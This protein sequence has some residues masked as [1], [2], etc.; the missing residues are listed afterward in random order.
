MGIYIITLAVVL[1]IGNP[2]SA[3]KAKL[4]IDRDTLRRF[5]HVVGLGSGTLLVAIL[6]GTE[7]RHAFMRALIFGEL[8]LQVRLHNQYV[9]GVP[10][11][12]LGFLAFSAYLLGV[13]SGRCARE[14][15]L[16]G[17]AYGL[18][19]VV[20]AAARG[21]KAP[22]IITVLVWSM[23]RWLAGR[24]VQWRRLALYALYAS[25]GGTGLLFTGIAL[26]D[27]GAAEDFFWYLLSRAGVGQMAGLFEAIALFGSGEMVHVEYL[28]HAIPGASV[29][30]NYVDFQKDLMMRVERYQFNEIGFKN[31]FFVAEAW[32]MGGPILAGV[33]P[34]WV[35]IS[36]GAGLL[37]WV[38]LWRLMLGERMAME[39]SPGLYILH[40]SLTGGFFQFPFFKSLIL[41]VIF[42]AAFGIWLKLIRP[43]CRSLVR[44]V[45]T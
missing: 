28:W 5:C 29:F 33:S 39:L 18:I 2:C 35:G 31:T 8:L 9:A 7:F 20:I 37:L 43:S 41:M 14:F 1:K 13:L 3:K 25:V 10:S 21:D 40:H 34:V 45:E 17:W 15:P 19:A 32:A 36:Y 12:I 38:R 42:F 23:A 27:P 22:V 26:Q 16:M 44:G 30:I 11:Q 24:P 6:I 4:N